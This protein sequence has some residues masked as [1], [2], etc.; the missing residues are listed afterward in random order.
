MIFINLDF[1]MTINTDQVHSKALIFRVL[2]YNS[3]M[4]AIRRP[5]LNRA[6]VSRCLFTPLLLLTGT[7]IISSNP[8]LR[9]SHMNR[10]CSW[11]LAFFTSRPYSLFTDI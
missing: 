3:M 1:T 5:L 9:L 11:Q 8:A 10:I 4:E 7:L 2:P 6:L